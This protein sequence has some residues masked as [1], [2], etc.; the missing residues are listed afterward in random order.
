[1]ACEDSSCVLSVGVRCRGWTIRSYAG[2]GA[3]ALVAGYAVRIRPR[4]PGGPVRFAIDRAECGARRVG[5]R[6]GPGRHPRA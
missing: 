4:F 3:R 2:A 5:S 6:R 1:M